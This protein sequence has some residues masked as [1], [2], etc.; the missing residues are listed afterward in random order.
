MCNFHFMKS[1]DCLNENKTPKIPLVVIGSPTAT[2]KTSLAIKLARLV[3]GEIINA[4][5]LQVYRGLDIGTAKPTQEERQGVPHHLIDV[6]S[7]DEDYN[8]ALYAEQARKLIE[9]LADAGKPVFVVGGTGLYIRALLSGMIQT[10]PV[11][12]NIRNFYRG[13]RDRHGRE[14]LYGLLRERDPQAAL[15]INPNDAIRV[16]RALEVLEQ[17]GQSIVTLQQ[18]HSFADCPYNAF[19]IGLS[20]DSDELKQRI[21]AR[22]EKMMEAGFLDEVQRLLAQGYS[23]KLKP[24]QSLGYRQIIDFIRGRSDWAE[25]LRL[26]NRDTWQ[27][28]KRQMTWFSADK[29]IHWFTPDQSDEIR[30]SLEVFRTKVF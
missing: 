13:L 22:T 19:K 29:T 21:A 6:V 16:I 20:A 5:S 23:D 24:L 30:K 7:P 8:A 25:T 12:E 10:P 11:D 3:G 9:I 28:S 1:K 2:G 17:S 26:I 4:D 15:R 14:Y 18:K 27:Y